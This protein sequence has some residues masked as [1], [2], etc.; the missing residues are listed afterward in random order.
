[1]KIEGR[2]DDDKKKYYT[3]LYNSLRSPTQWDEV[4]GVYLGFDGKVRKVPAHMSHVY[5]DLSI[6][7][8]HRT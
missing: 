7:D 5:T 3:S 8:V 6:W 4:D 1:M 2:D